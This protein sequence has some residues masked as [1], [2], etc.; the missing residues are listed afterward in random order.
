MRDQDIA[1]QL[2]E[3]VQ[4]VANLEKHFTNHVSV[5]LWDRVLHTVYTLAVILM[6]CYLKWGK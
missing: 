6:F 4:Q 5:H 3:V 1:F 2:G